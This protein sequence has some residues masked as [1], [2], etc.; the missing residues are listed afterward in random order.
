MT[1]K[2]QTNQLLGYPPD[3]RLL[4]INMDDFGMC[5]A[6]NQATLDTFKRGIST[7]CTLM[8]P[9]PWALHSMHLL[10]ENPDLPFGVHLTAVSENL[11]YRWRPLSC[12]EKA[13]TLVDEKEYFYSEERIPEFLGQVNLAE[14]ELEFRAQIE[15][16]L[17]EGLK[18]THLDSHCG[19][20]T[21]REDIFDMTVQ[22]AREYSVALRL[23]ERPL[24]EKLQRQ[25]YAINDYDILDSYELENE[26]KPILY[27]KL[28]RELPTGLS[29]WAIHPG[30]GNAELQ[31]MTPTWPVRQADYD[32]FTSPEAQTIIEEEGIILLNYKPL[33]ELWRKKS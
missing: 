26:A 17:A 20:H 21:R 29:E 30:L 12:L 16:V 24:I 23:T 13:P 5:H 11:Y 27:P 1:T 18:P 25:G 10:K 2:D 22:L 4:I 28:L 14:L 8:V 32:F 31:A 15:V 33:Q 3:A 19:I 6:I 7:S 9:C